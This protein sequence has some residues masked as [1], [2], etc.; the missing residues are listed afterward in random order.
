MTILQDFEVKRFETNLDNGVRV[1]L[2]R[3]IGAPVRTSAILKSGSRYDRENVQGTAH[4][5]EHMITNGSER[6][7]S[8]DLW[9][10][11]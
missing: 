2:F 10:N 11:I 8:K 7:P 3:K 9:L 6:F 5:L 1:V 4:F